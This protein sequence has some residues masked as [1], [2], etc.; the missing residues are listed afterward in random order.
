MSPLMVS[1]VQVSQAKRC[2]TSYFY[3]HVT[4]PHF[5]LL[6]LISVIL[7]GQNIYSVAAT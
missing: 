2:I 1:S 5:I 4:C 3:M 7:F 6:D